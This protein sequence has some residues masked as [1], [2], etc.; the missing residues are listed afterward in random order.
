MTLTIFFDAF[1]GDY[2]DLYEHSFVFDKLLHVFGSYAFSLFAYTLVAQLPGTQIGRPA[3]FILTLCL[4]V[5]LGVFYEISEF[6]GDLV[7][8]PMPP[9]QPGLLDTDLDLVGDTIG[10]FFA[11]VQAALKKSSV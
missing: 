2:F 1:F 4:G 11:A 9:N 8:H 10:A 5:S 3:R 7:S 6:I